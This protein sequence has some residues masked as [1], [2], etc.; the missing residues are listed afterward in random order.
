MKTGVIFPERLRQ[1][2]AVGIVAPASP[3]DQQRFDKGIRR[4]TSAGYHPVVSKGLFDRQGYLAGSDQHRA[5]LINRF[6]LDRSVKAIVCARGGYGSMRMLGFLNYDAIH[7]HPKIIVGFSDITALLNAIFFQ[8]R[9]VTFHGPNVTTLGD[10]N[11]RTRDS[12]FSTLTSDSP[13]RM[14]V[15]KGVTLCRGRATG[16]VIGGNLT[17]LCHLTGTHFAPDYKGCILLLEDRGEAPYRIDRMLTQMKLTGCFDYLAGIV[18]GSFEQ[19]GTPEAVFD[20]FREMF[21]KFTIPVLGGLD[22]G[23]GRT[24]LIVPIGL[25]ATL[26]ADRKTLTFDR[27]A[28]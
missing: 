4:L 24:N 22:V 5:D 18:L 11:A 21:E 20:I 9:L 7:R 16:V 1:G 28:T 23:H 8:S 17:T 3:F 13:M 26:D 12:F 25:T 27:A 14:D 15:E 2:D 19:C 10:R 6:F